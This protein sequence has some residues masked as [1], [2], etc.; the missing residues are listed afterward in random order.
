M[1]WFV[2]SSVSRLLV[3]GDRA[4]DVD[5]PL[6]VGLVGQ[7]DGFDGVPAAPVPVHEHRGHQ[8]ETEQSTELHGRFTLPE[9]RGAIWHL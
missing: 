8:H 5:V 3:L 7:V 1:R 2:G 9:F 4:V 6:L